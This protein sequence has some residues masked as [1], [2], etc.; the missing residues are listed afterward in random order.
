GEVHSRGSELLNQIRKVIDD[1]GLRFATPLEA[2]GELA[3]IAFEQER[4]PIVVRHKALTLGSRSLDRLIG[5]FR[6][7]DLGSPIC[8]PFAVRAGTNE[9]GPWSDPSQRDNSSRSAVK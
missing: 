6:F 1:V 9:S 3:A 7:S 5:A 8:S 2:E 4:Q